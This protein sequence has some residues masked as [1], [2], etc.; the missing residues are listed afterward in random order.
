MT[1]SLAGVEL[2]GPDSFLEFAH[3]SSGRA[4]SVPR[5]VP[6]PDPDAAER[7]ESAMA[8]DGRGCAPQAAQAPG[9]GPVQAPLDADVRPPPAPARPSC[10]VRMLVAAADAV[11]DAILVS[12][13]FAG[14]EGVLFVRLRPEVLDGS[15]VRIVA[16]GGDLAVEIEPATQ[17]VMDAVEA[18]RTRFEQH[19]AGKVHAW[20]VSVSVK[21]REASDER[22]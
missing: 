16:K 20:R 13:G 22:I 5:F 7:F 15:E 4:V 17:D 1:Q 2:A 9:H 18:N 10:D 21:R 6:Y 8:D 14:G 12:D 11:A 3:G 19:L